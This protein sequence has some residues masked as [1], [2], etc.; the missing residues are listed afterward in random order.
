MALHKYSV[1]MNKC[2]KPTLRSSP[3]VSR[4]KFSYMK[5]GYFWRSSLAD[6]FFVGRSFSSDLREQD[7]NEDNLARRS[8]EFAAKTTL[9]RSL[10]CAGR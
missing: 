3:A 10:A 9:Q 7:S 8:T 6:V 4:E 5:T 1:E 2:A